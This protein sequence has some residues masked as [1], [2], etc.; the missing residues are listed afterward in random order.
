MRSRL[1]LAAGAVA[2]QLGAG[3]GAPAP[4]DAAGAGAAR[5]ERPLRDPAGGG[6][7]GV[8][9][10]EER[11]PCADRSATRM[12]LFGDLH[13][14]TSL[15]FDAAAREVRTTPADAYRFGRGEAIPFWPLD[16]S[17]DPA[18]SIAIDRP[19]DFLAVTDHGEFLGERALC[20]T[21][22]SPGHDSAYCRRFR[23]SDLSSAGMLGEI[24]TSER[25]LRPA[26]LCGADGGAVSRVGLGSLAADRRGRRG[27]LRPQPRV[28]L[29]DLRRLRVHEHPGS[30]EPPPQRDLP[31]RGGPGRAGLLP[32][33]AARPP[34]LEA[35]GRGLLPP[36]AAATI[37]RSPTTR[38]WPTG[39]WLRTTV[40]IRHPRPAGSTR[41]RA[42]CASRSWRSSS[43]RAARS[44]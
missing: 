12:A 40:S 9:Y 33:G 23:G 5:P 25:P 39:A 37:S 42:S 30:V 6:A 20:L 11:S 24:I 19:L 3:C 27:G 29:H 15:S 31:Q 7:A 21:F 8:T 36:R 26:E 22:G 13:V 4:G 10:T 2:V 43:T 44:A 1:V 32:G 28:P 34:A 17:G 41:G 14:H 38:T 18:A 16:A 35:A